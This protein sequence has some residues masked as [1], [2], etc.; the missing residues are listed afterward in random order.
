MAEV[1]IRPV[2]EKDVPLVLV[3][4]QELAKYEPPRGSIRANSVC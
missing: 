1:R 4:I 2:T 3:L